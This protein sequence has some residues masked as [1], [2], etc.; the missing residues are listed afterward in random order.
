MNPRPAHDFQP[1]LADLT[2]LCWQK[3]I[4][5]RAGARPSCTEPHI[6]LQGISDRCESLLQVHVRD[7]TRFSCLLALIA[8]L[9]SPLSPP[10]L[11]NC[12]LK[13]VV[14][15]LRERARSDDVS[16]IDA[17]GYTLHGG[18]LMMNSGVIVNCA[19]A[20]QSGG[21]VRQDARWAELR[22]GSASCSAT[23]VLLC[24]VAF[25]HSVRPRGVLRAAPITS[26]CCMIFQVRAA[27][28][29][30][31]LHSQTSTV[32]PRQATVCS[33]VAQ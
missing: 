20:F 19:L 18:T 2:L 26:Q 6:C 4:C 22:E 3:Q 23:C 11:F 21:H 32:F 14:V 12:C 10:S 27:D 30:A 16:A 8:P 24:C 5:S 33:G 15:R 1:G 29:L 28:C 7:N 17:A 9:W 31:V 25:M 13:R